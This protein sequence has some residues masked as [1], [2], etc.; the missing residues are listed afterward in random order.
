[1]AETKEK[2]VVAKKTRVPRIPHL[3]VGKEVVV[4]LVNGAFVF[5]ATQTMTIDANA[6]VHVGRVRVPSGYALMLTGT[7]L[8]E[9]KLLIVSPT[10]CVGAAQLGVF[11]TNTSPELR[12]LYAG[13][14][15]AIGVLVKIS[16]NAVVNKFE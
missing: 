6:Y 5:K 4:E 2:K 8:M 12:R 16:D 1:M 15:V 7:R 3:E 11:C 13:E 10:T 9:K 14:A